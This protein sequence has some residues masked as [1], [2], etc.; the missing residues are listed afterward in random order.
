VDTRL[1]RLRQCVARGDR[2]R[3]VRYLRW[4]ALDDATL[5]RRLSPV[6]FTGAA[7]PPWA[8]LLQR[9][10]AASPPP[11]GVLIAGAPEP[12]EEALAPLLNAAIDRVRAAIPRGDA[13]FD[14]A[15]PGFSRALLRQ[16]GRIAGRTLY[17]EFGAFRLRAT[18]DGWIDE[19]A[20]SSSLAV[21]VGGSDRVHYD[22]FIAHLAR[23]ALDRILLTYPM[24]ARLL[25]TRALSWAESTSEFLLR[26]AADGPHLARTV[27]ARAPLGPIV[28]VTAD[29]SDPHHGG[30]TV[31]RVTFA[32]G[33]QAIYKPRNLQL[34]AAFSSLLDWLNERSLPLPLKAPR[35]CDR[36]SY[37]WME[38]VPAAPCRDV[39]DVER[40]YHRAGMLLC[41]AYVLGGAD[42]HQGNVIASGEHP[43]LIDLEVLMGAPPRPNPSTGIRHETDGAQVWDSVLRTG[44]LPVNRFGLNGGRH[45]RGGLA[46]TDPGVGRRVPH[47][48]RVNTDLMTLELRDPLAA[49]LNVPHVAGR[50]VTFEGYAPAVA[51]GFAEMSSVLRRARRD[52]IA[53]RGPLAPFRGAR[54]RVV[55]RATAV[56]A[57]VLERVLHPRLLRDGADWSIELEVLES[58]PTAHLSRPRYWATWLAEQRSLARLDVPV[59]DS[60]TN[61]CAIAADG[62][63]LA[64]DYLAESGYDGALRR[65]GE[66]D[67]ARTRVH[68]QCIRLV[69]RS[70]RAM[71]STGRVDAVAGMSDRARA[72]VSE[73]VRIATTLRAIA[74]E[75]AHDGIDWV[76]IRGLNGTTQ[77]RMQ[78]VGW[79]L[80]SGRCGI[81]LLFAALESR[82]LLES[83]PSFA[84]RIVKPLVDVLLTGTRLESRPSPA[85]GAFG[86]GG[87][88]YG[89]ATTSRLLGSSALLDAAA[90]AA[91][92]IT[93]DAISRDRRLDVMFGSAGAALGLL[94]LHRLEPRPDLLDR[95]VACGRRLL[96][97][98]E[99]E[100]SPR[101]ARRPV[102]ARAA[103]GFAHGAAGMAFTLARL[104]RETG[105]DMF[106]DAAVATLAR[107]ALAERRASASASAASLERMR[108]SWCQG[109]AGVGL[110]RLEVSRLVGHPDARAG[111]ETLL[112]ELI[113]P[114]AGLS[115]SDQVCCGN[116]GNLELLARAT[117]VLGDAAWREAAEDRA[118]QVLARAAQRGGYALSAVDDA[119]SPGYY[120]GLS[121]IG[122]EFLRLGV[123]D[124]PAVLLWE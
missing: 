104:Y 69:A 54:K 103:A 26:V 13:T 100:D 117:H 124:L 10:D 20:F 99:G 15:L 27:A 47:W 14:G 118:G 53:E 91:A 121:G 43:V 33:A 88:V 37:G 2:A 32:S 50:P 74:D 16:F 58:A 62:E 30:R 28:D 45:R 60:T 7:L 101:T 66:L 112:A 93:F 109:I 42:L 29:L 75:S 55:L 114:T 107:E 67:A 49:H 108:R 57:T 21:V 77:R 97:H 59:F 68:L 116:A 36:G 25:A 3:F 38:C 80:Y 71:S 17:A 52:L 86:A 70:P 110:A 22:A 113:V 1:E 82:G 34:E 65:I 84:A 8:T 90:R 4:N 72:W 51:K 73:A 115:P 6:D 111:L 94:A 19:G 35:V 61:G 41:L 79:D 24:L 81:G 98:V 23:G 48:R 12:F 120:Q 85:I 64:G 18:V 31:C 105:T 56:Y 123:R 122:Y 9:M 63:E 119:F 46:D 40:Y 92:T 76:G 44:L 95:A 106:R 83:E 87:I 5:R 39:A 96:R 78:S 102:R 89:L 11:A